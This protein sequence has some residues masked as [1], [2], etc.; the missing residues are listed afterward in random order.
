MLQALLEERFKLK[1]HRET[2]EVPVYVLTVASGGLRIP[3]AADSSCVPSDYSNFPRSALP[4]GK[5]RCNDIVGR[6]G[7]NTVLNAEEATIDY[8]SE[9]LSLALNRPIVYKGGIPGKYNFHLEFPTDQTASSGVRGLPVLPADEPS[10]A[11]VFTVMQEQLGLKLE[12]ASG[13]RE[14]LIVDHVERPSAN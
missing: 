14:F 11:S 12:P 5:R 13:P 9:I 7:S 4:P 10:A 2:R 1:T 6:K 3:R 8:F